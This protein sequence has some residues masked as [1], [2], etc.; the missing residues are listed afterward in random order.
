MVDM[1]VFQEALS[2]IPANEVE[3]CFSDF[4]EVEFNTE[5]QKT[6]EITPE[7]H[8]YVTK[9]LNGNIQKLISKV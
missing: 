5:A 7:K 1:K 8:A 2:R 6:S 9:A 4:K 3:E